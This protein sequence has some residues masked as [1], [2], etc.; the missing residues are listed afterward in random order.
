MKIE[1]IRNIST[2]RWIQVGT[3]SY[4]SALKSGQLDL[5]TCSVDLFCNTIFTSN[6]KEPKEPKEHLQ[7]TLQDVLNTLIQ[8]NFDEF[9]ESHVDLIFFTLTDVTATRRH[10]KQLCCTPSFVAFVDRIIQKFGIRKSIEYALTNFR[11]KN[12][13]YRNVYDHPCFTIESTEFY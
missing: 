6:S 10:L 2:N 12:I 11:T 4:Y 8:L 9:Q 5:T 7:N 1:K 3:K 13:G